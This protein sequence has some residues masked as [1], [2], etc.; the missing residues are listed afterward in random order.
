MVGFFALCLWLLAGLLAGWLAGLVTRGR[1]Y[2]CCADILLG[3]LGAIAGGF[4]FSAIFGLKPGGFLGS[5]FVAFVGALVL[6]LF[7]RLI[8]GL[9][10]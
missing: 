1:G 10:R 7:A 4:L 3:W 5:V 6:L 9:A 8:A 2:G